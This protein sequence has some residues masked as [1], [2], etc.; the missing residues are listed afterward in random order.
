MGK[1]RSYEGLMTEGFSILH[2]TATTATTY[3]LTPDQQTC[4][5]D[6]TSN[7]GNIVIELPPLDHPGVRGKIYSIRLT[8]L[9]TSDV[10]V[11]DANSLATL[12]TLDTSADNVQVYSD[13]LRWI[14][15]SGTYT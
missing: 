6:S 10:A 8:T 5:V 4:L 13:R 9:D 12:Y 15:L 14:A 3:S 2:V 1:D 11:D 7:A